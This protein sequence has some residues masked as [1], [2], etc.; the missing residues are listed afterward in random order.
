[1]FSEYS[2]S[3]HVTHDGR[4]ELADR[5]A[6]TKAMRDFKRGVVTV[7]VTHGADVYTGRRYRYY[8]G[9]VLK[10]IAEHTGDDVEDLHLFFKKRFTQPIE[11]TVLGERFLVWTT[12]ELND[13]Q[14]KAFEDEVR[15]FARTELQ[16]ETPDPDP[17]MRGQR[18][19][20]TVN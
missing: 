5:D 19:K 11:K 16:V 10:L 17:E 3:A 15:R 13:E 14:F 1:M 7:R 6:F 8:R 2:V 4:L 18:R 20:A 9:I 12:T